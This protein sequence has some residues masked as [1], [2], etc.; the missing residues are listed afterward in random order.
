[1]ATLAFFVALGGTASASLIITSNSQ[2]ASKTISGHHPPAGKHANV[3]KGSINATDLAQG[4]VTGGKIA[5]GAVGN[6]KLAVNAVTG[7]RVLDG[8]L[9]GD[10]IDEATLVVSPSGP[11]GGDLSGTYP[12]PTIADGAVTS[13]KLGA[14]AV[15]SSKVLDNSL[16][17]ADVL[18][19]GLSD[20]DIGSPAQVNGADL[21]SI[22]ANQCINVN[23][24][25]GGWTQ[26]GELVIV[27]ARDGRYGQQGIFF[28]PFAVATSGT[29]SGRVCNVSTAALDPPAEDILAFSIRQ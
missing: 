14:S 11:A 2:V 25:F 6:R 27:S 23:L 24:N 22:P 21:P 19:R 7:T 18:N 20:S 28:T 17:G 29:A 13:A 9:T 5:V 1:M 26:V 15:D 16:T 10:D 4:A 3:I 12:N 8:S